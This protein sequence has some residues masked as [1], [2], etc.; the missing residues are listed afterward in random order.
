MNN[1]SADTMSKPGLVNVRLASL[2]GKGD[3]IHARLPLGRVPEISQT[4]MNILMPNNS[5]QLLFC[6]MHAPVSVSEVVEA[7]YHVFRFKPS[8]Q[9]RAVDLV[10][11][12]RSEVKVVYGCRRRALHDD[13]VSDNVLPVTAECKENK[14]EFPISVYRRSCSGRVIRVPRGCARRHGDWHFDSRIL[15]H[16]T[17][18]SN[19]IACWCS[20]SV[21]VMLTSSDV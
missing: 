18:E 20:T 21:S 10:T 9:Q 3:K 7:P 2:N 12:L 19:R 5:A 14:L 4:A 13:E 16:C 1:A 11:P 8:L 6:M 17:N 15:S